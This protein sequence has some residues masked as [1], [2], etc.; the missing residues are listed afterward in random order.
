[1]QS[2]EMFSSQT[3]MDALLFVKDPEIGLNIVE[4]ALVY[5]VQ[6]DARGNVSIKMT[7]TSPGCGLAGS[8]VQDVQQ[9][10]RE[11]VPKAKEV[12]VDIVFDPPWN[13]ANMSEEA[14]KKVGFDE[15]MM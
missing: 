7:L 6:V 4:M 12:R 11:R 3:V 2:Y 9:T 14:K 13:P 10:V 8:I 1:M 5:D 15:S